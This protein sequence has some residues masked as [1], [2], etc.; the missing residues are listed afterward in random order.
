MRRHPGLPAASALSARS[1]MPGLDLG[2]H[3]E[4]RLA[5]DPR[6]ELG[7]DARPRRRRTL[8]AACP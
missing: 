2:I 5:T 4:A 6:T 1:V 8:V 7:D 3:P